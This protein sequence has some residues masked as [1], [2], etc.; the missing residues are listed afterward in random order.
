MKF[1]SDMKKQIELLAPA[2]DC[3]VGITAINYGADAVYIGP[4]RY[5]ARQ[6]VGNSLIDIE[7]LVNYAHKYWARVYATVNTLLYDDEVDQAVELCHQLYQAGV[8]ALIIQDF[9]LLE[10]NLPPIPLFAS[11]QMHNHTPERVKFL[12]QVGIQ[13]V[14][15]ARELSLDQLAEIHAAT[16]IELETFIHGAL[17]VSFSGQCALSYAIGGRS[18]NRGQCA[19]PCR[20]VY[21]LQDRSG[22]QP[23]KP[24]HL[25][26][27]KDLNLSDYLVDLLNAGVCSFK[28]EGRLKDRNYVQNVVAHY[29]QRLDEILPDLDLQASSSGNVKLD[30]QPDPDKTFNRG[31]TSHFITG[32]RGDI[33]S[34]KTPKHAGE[35]VGFVTKIAENSFTLNVPAMLNNG[36]GITFFD[37]GG[38][39]NGTQVNSVEGNIIYPARMSGISTGAQ[40]CRNADRRFL[41]QLEKSKPG[42]KIPI[43][44]RFSETRDGFQLS[45]KDQ[46]G[47]VVGVRAP[48]EKNPANKP[49]QA[50]KTMLQQLTR[51]GDSIF[52][53][54]EIVIEHSKV[55]FFPISVLNGLRRDLVSALLLERERTFPRWKVEIQPNDYPY[56]TPEL[57]FLG[58]VLNQKAADFFRRHGVHTIEPAAETGLEMQGRK[59]MTTK[60]CI[61]YELGGCPHSKQPI[62]IDEPL[63]L[64]DEDGLRLRLAFNCRDC[65]MDV[66]FDRVGR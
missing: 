19:Q 16:T 49:A 65:V 46:N 60:Y 29:R 45:A 36:D 35:P 26:S 15:L 66:Y 17:C 9:G 28:I 61:K 43:Y 3:D 55:Y 48:L 7:K 56:P 1:N 14:I 47:N 38:N 12:E 25:L 22:N 6:A 30:F 39:L 2:R 37:P 24:G 51:L 42:R 33:S 13:R 44:I 23:V 57:T 52:S 31:Y 10:C 53:C 59:V 64:T 8:D 32:E 5:G 11:T 4:A 21:S 54:S 18:G 63:F 62:E 20:R 34:W 40:I 50:Q 41:K 27:I 58:N